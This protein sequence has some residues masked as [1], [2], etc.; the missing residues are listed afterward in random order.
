MCLSVS[1]SVFKHNGRPAKTDEPI[2]MPFWGVDS[3]GLTEPRIRRGPG[4]P[5]EETIFGEPP[6]DA[7]FCYN[8]L[9]TRQ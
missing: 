4:S 7:A 1:L 6:C 2:E 9:T 3:G 5:G 8:S